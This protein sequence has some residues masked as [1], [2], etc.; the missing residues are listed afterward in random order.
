[1]NEYVRIEG[2]IIGKM[3]DKKRRD[4]YLNIKIQQFDKGM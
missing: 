2:D 1:M 4:L 3:T